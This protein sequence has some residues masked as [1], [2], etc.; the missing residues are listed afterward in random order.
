MCIQQ[1]GN[2]RE[3]NGR[4]GTLSLVIKESDQGWREGPLKSMEGERCGHQYG[5]RE[6]AV[7]WS[8]VWREEGVVISTEGGRCGH[9]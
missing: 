1:V 9:N 6:L 8:Q 2:E 7:Q 5:G 4:E 3:G